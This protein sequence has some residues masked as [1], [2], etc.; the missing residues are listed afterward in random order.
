MKNILSKISL[1]MLIAQLIIFLILG[2]IA[3]RILYPLPEVQQ[4]TT[5]HYGTIIPDE[6]LGW[7]PKSN[8]AFTDTLLDSNG[9]YYPVDYQSDKNGFRV[10]GDVDQDSL[11]K[12][13]FI[14]DSFTQAAEVSNGKTFYNVFQDSFPSEIFAFGSSGF[15]TLQEFLVFQK[16]FEII[17]PDMVIWQLCSNDFID[18]HIKL[19]KAS[20]YKNQKRRPYLVKSE[21]EYHSSERVIYNFLMRNSALFYNL[22]MLVKKVIWKFNLE[23]YGEI[24]IVNQGKDYKRFK[25]AFDITD[26]IFKRI[27]SVIGDQAK[28]V[29]FCADYS[30]PQFS[31]LSE[32]AN[33]N[34]ILFIEDNV[35][36]LNEAKDANEVIFCYDN[37]HWNE[38]GHLVVG[39]AIVTAL[40]RNQIIQ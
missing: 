12:V 9:E 18:N 6:E 30:E 24:R 8:H 3:T 7:L 37:I 15:G 1:K 40:R 32:V 35:H 31:F 19:E 17:K 16:Y 38:Y 11:P 10:F 28:L 13:L 25:T 39:N 14:G 4:E 27:N 23:N 5:I 34:S 22:D 2:E 20:L 36:R 29:M 26:E 21:I 33:N